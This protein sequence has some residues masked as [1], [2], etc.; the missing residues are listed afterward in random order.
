[1]EGG[2]EEEMKI[3]LEPTEEFFR[4]DD[5]FPVR[6]WKGNTDKG[7]PIIAFIAAI[8]SQDGFDHSELERELKT[9]PGPNVS[10]TAVRDQ[11]I[12]FARFWY[13]PERFLESKDAAL[14][15][16]DLLLSTLTLSNNQ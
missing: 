8:S 7:R 16:A 14:K 2:S 6:A 15:W 11:W 13:G 5:G 1:M 3:T 12:E 4:T 10:K 9:I